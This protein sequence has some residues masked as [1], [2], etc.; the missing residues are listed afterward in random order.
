M[1]TTLG[2]NN[3]LKLYFRKETETWTYRWYVKHVE[4]LYILG[5]YGVSGYVCIEN[6]S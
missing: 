2:A 6:I 5:F 4:Y 3:R 1:K